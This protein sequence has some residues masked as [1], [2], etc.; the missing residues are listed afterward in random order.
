MRESS[1][2]TTK[3]LKLL[4]A[5]SGNSHHDKKRNKILLKLQ[6]GRETSLYTLSSE[7]ITVRIS[8]HIATV[9]ALIR[10][11]VQVNIKTSCLD[12]TALANM[13]VTAPVSAQ[14]AAVLPTG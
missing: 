4:T 7:N 1:S 3:A 6:D 13:N 12:L 14:Y 2:V 11:P 8:D 9:V 10:A 5:L